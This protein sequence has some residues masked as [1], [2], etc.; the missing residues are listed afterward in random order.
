MRLSARK[1]THLG[2]VIKVIVLSVILLSVFRLEVMA[3][4]NV[5]ISGSVK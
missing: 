5:G 4:A 1:I 2:I 3:P